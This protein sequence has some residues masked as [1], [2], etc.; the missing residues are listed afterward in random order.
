MLQ[1]QLKRIKNLP[2]LGRILVT[3]GI[4]LKKK[5]FLITGGSSG[6]GMQL[7]LDEI[8]LG[9]KVV[10][11]DINEPNFAHTI[12]SESMDSPP[13]LSLSLSPSLD[14]NVNL[15]IFLKVDLRDIKMV[16]QAAKELTALKV[17]DVV[18][19]N[20]CHFVMGK[21]GKI[22]DYESLEESMNVNLTSPIILINELMDC[23][24]LA[25]NPLV[26]NI[27][28]TAANGAPFCSP[29]A[30]TKGGI[31]SFGKAINEEFRINGNLKCIN[32]ILGALDGGFSLREAHEA[33][34]PVPGKDSVIPVS[35][36]SKFIVK[37]IDYA[38]YFDIT[39]ITLKPSKMNIFNPEFEV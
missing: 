27:S 8:L 31:L 9:A 18:I 19:N 13:S 39:E 37:L 25:T 1:L 32:L 12:F 38:E 10:F 20:A 11:L 15:P 14:S 6:L 17:V 3:T 23:L 7:V 5:T 4:R 36:L 35:P 28:S 30:V 2:T 29:Y 16:S 22:S 33:V 26:I 21:L 34:T 24:N